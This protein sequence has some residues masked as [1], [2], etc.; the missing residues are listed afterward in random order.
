MVSLHGLALKQDQSY[1]MGLGS[2]ALVNV[3][4]LEYES[5]RSA[6][7]SLIWFTFFA[8][9]ACGETNLPDLSP[10]IASLFPLGGRVGE[11]VELQ[12][13][14]RNLDGAQSITFPRADIQAEVLDSGFSR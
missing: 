12:I 5:M 1:I 7:R 4:V 13:H 6:R 3:L 9:L 2:Q 8:T 10:S 14:G 11:T